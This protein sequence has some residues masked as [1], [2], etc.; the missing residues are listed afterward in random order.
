MRQ[1]RPQPHPA[2]LDLIL[3]RLK[4]IERMVQEN[5]QDILTSQQLDLTRNE[6]TITKGQY[7]RA[8][9]T[10]EK[11]FEQL[12]GDVIAE[13]DFVDKTTFAYLDSIP[14]SCGIH[15]IVSNIKGTEKILN[16]AEKCSR[17]RPYFEMIKINK[18]HQRWIGSNESFFIDLGTDLK[19]DALG[20]CTHTIR[21]LAPDTFKETI[22]HFEQLWNKSEHELKQMYG[23]DFS[24]SIVY[25]SGS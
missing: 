22:S 23:K 2:P 12:N 11:W 9:Q 6:V 8:E 16:K 7:N 10:I 5:M 1:T 19:S 24:K 4:E 25:R 15:I 21:K 20:H 13:L 18:I 3:T 17:D 14:K